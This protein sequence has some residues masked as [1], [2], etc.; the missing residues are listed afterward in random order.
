MLFWPSYMH[1][2]VSMHTRAHM[3]TSHT[4]THKSEEN[5]YEEKNNF[6]FREDVCVCCLEEELG[7]LRL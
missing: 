5:D 3:H 4:H 7:L 2:Q 1:T 6:I